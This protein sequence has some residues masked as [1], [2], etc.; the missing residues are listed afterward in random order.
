MHVSTPIVHVRYIGSSIISANSK[1]SIEIKKCTKIYYQ[2]L[3][4]KNFPKLLLA[5]FFSFM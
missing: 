3:N 2:R 1:Y 4:V 5:W